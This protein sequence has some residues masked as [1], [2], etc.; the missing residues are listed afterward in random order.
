MGGSGHL[1]AVRPGVLIWRDS[2]AEP[3]GTPRFATASGA[4]SEGRSGFQPLPRSPAA[5]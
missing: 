1:A 5:L 4:W 2:V 3:P